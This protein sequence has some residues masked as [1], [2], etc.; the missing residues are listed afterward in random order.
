MVEVSK[1]EEIL[2]CAQSLIVAGGY[3]GF[4][5]ADISKVVGIRNASIHHHFPSK[6]DLVVAAVEQQRAA[7]QAQ[8]EAVENDAPNA[9]EQLLAYVDYWKRCIEDQSAPFCLAGVLAV[10]LPGLPPEVGI[11]VKG[12]FNDLGL[13]LN[14][15]MTLGVEQGTI[16]LELEPGVSSQFFQTTIYGAMVMARAYND[17]RKFNFVVDAFL[18]RMRVDGRKSK[19]ARV[20]K[21]T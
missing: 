4:S 12:H 10:E 3:N 17:P 11:A 1:R 5:Y 14:R 20:R 16:Q 2:R 19:K 21:S 7:I 8:I 18:A 9:M 15:V 13:W 6:V